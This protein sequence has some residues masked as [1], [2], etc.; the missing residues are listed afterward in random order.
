MFLFA[1]FWGRRDDQSVT[2]RYMRLK[3]WSNDLKSAC[4][5]PNYTGCA[6]WFSRLWAF[7]QPLGV[8]TAS[9]FPASQISVNRA[10]CE[11]AR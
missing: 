1:K 9:T 4:G 11:K 6:V 8:R 10:A 7:T 3:H 2:Q 5:M